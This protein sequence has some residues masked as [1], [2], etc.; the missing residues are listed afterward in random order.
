MSAT[1]DYQAIFDNLKSIL[2][3]AA[4]FCDD[5]TKANSENL[6]DVIC[7]GHKV[8]DRLTHYDAEGLKF[9]MELEAAATKLPQI[10]E[11]E[12]GKRYVIDGG[13]YFMATEWSDYGGLIHN[14]Y[15]LVDQNGA[16]TGITVRSWVKPNFARS[17]NDYEAHLRPA[18]K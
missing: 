4:L 13:F 12:L 9:W 11:F 18:I 2:K 14:G 17:T 1:A 5:R 16:N 8:I 7:E 3:A 15:S 10:A 6:R